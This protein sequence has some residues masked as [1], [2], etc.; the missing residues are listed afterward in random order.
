MP[1]DIPFSTFTKILCIL[2]LDNSAD[3]LV[4]TGETF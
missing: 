3:I 2:H 1:G 4:E